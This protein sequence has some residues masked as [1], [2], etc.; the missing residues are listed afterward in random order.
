SSPLDWSASFE[1]RASTLKRFNPLPYLLQLLQEVH[2]L[3]LQSSEL[4]IVLSE[5]YSNALE[6]GVLGL[7]SALKRDAQGFALYYQQR[8]ERLDNL[9]YGFIRFDFQIV[10]VAQGGRLTVQVH[11][12]GS[13]FDA[14]QTLS[15][16]P[17]INQLSGR[18]LSLV[19]QLSDQC[20]WSDDGRTACVEFAWEGLA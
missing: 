3:R 19:R 5:L 7:D 9:K 20:R 17:A 6:H 14:V 15:L 16:P 13:G 8:G 12:S 18:G 2:G 11:D 4:Y 10:P 1:F